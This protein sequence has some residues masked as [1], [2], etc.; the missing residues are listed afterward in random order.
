MTGKTRHQ[1]DEY[2]SAQ[3]AARRAANALRTLP[4]PGQGIDF[5]S[6]DYLGLA[7]QPFDPPA[8]SSLFGA[9]GSRLI[10]GNHEAYNRLESSLADFLQT[11]SALV[12]GSGYQANLGLISSVTT[13]HDT[14]L[15]DELAH[16][17]IRDALQLATARSFAFRHNDSQHLREKLQRA[18]G[19]VFVVVESIYSMD[20]DEAPLREIA[21]LCAEAGAALIVDEA[22]A[23]GVIGPG[24]S[25]LSVELGLAREVWA[26]VVT[27]GKALGSHGAAVIGSRL[28]RDYLIN[29]S[30]PFIYTTGM[31]PETIHRIS[32]SVQYVRRHDLVDLLRMRIELFQSRLS[33]RV[34]LRLIPSRSA[35]QSLVVPGNDEIKQLAGELQAAGFQVLPILHPTVPK[36]K[37]RI[38]ICLHVF[39]READILRLADTLNASV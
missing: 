25:G 19:R 3:L 12:Y 13:R 20:G 34:R 4:E 23:I 29:F 5:C 15:Y 1:V 38:R 24:G 6:N 36:G 28:L 9:T 32:E 2:L 10:S 11:E 21:E 8:E 14:I 37:E 26:R 7:R 22:H 31:P 30:R 35:I 18:G 16:A 27:F 39:N 17:S 33:D